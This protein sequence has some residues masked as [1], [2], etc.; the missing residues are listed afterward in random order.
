VSAFRTLLWWLLLAAF[1]AL[2]FELLARDPGELVLRWHGFTTTTTVAFALVAWGLLWFLAWLLWTLLRLPFTAWHR[3]AQAQSRKRLFNGLVALHEGRHARALALLEKAAEDDDVAG[4][5]RIAAR[6]AALRSG[7]L[8]TAATQ[9][10]A[11]AQLDPLAAA[12]CS[13]EAALARGDATTAL[14]ALQ[15]WH[16]RQALPPRAARLRGEAL[17]A[18]ERAAEALPLL[19]L[20]A[21]EKED[22]GDAMIALENRWQAAA[23]MQSAHANELQQRWQALPALLREQ[24]QVLC[25]YAARAGALGLEAE[26]AHALGDALERRWDESLLAAFA[27]LPMAREDQRLARARGWLSAHADSAAL[28]LA[29]GQL[30]LRAQQLGIAEEMLTRAIAQGAGASAWELLGEV[31]TARDDAARAQVCF[32]NALRLQRGMD[33]VPLSGRSLREQIADEA[34]AEQRDELGLPRLRS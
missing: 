1:G 27:A 17:L 6:E 34:V 8:A 7:D 22:G 3:L 2:A 20:L 13:A 10:T 18:N 23:L 5:A 32:A 30:S 11:L 26:A 9:L 16:D 28:A 33:A 12:I 25:A 4:V 31:Y 29:L 19:A 24:A 15:P 21:R 14:D